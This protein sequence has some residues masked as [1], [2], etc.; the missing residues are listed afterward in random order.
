MQWLSYLFKN[1]QIPSK[2]LTDKYIPENLK[3]WIKTGEENINKY[4]I[5]RCNLFKHK[6]QP[7]LS[8]NG[9]YKLAER[10]LNFSKRFINY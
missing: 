4:G 1:K 9:T 2:Q 8:I 7:I 5:K 6:L 10:S 3:T